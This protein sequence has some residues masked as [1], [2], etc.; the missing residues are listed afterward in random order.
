MIQFVEA[1]IRQKV[2][3]LYT[4]NTDPHRSQ[5]MNNTRKLQDKNFLLSNQNY[6]NFSG[7]CG[8]FCGLK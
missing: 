8:L 2:T 3:P 5:S 1:K 7:H 6:N 4:F